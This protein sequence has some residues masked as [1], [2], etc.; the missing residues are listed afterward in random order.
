MSGG[1]SICSFWCLGPWLLLWSMQIFEWWYYKKYGISFL[2]QLSI[3][4]LTPWFGGTGVTNAGTDSERSSSSGESSPE[5]GNDCLFL[6]M[7]LN[8]KTYPMRKCFFTEVQ[9]SENPYKLFRGPEYSR[10]LKLRGKKSPR[11]SPLFRLIDWLIEGLMSSAKTFRLVIQLIDWLIA[12][13]LQLVFV[14][15]HWFIDFKIPVDS[16]ID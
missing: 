11:Y 8:L 12:C 5:Q 9:V 2:E 13:F 15:I 14:L 1:I 4:H 6:C 3:T 7:S 10:F 16:L